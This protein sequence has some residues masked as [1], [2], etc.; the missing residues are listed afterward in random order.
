[1]SSLQEISREC[2]IYSTLMR[3]DVP[4]EAPDFVSARRKLMSHI[5]RPADCHKV[6][7]KAREL[8]NSGTLLMKGKTL[9]LNEERV[10]ERIGALLRCADSSHPGSHHWDDALKQ[11]LREL[12]QQLWV[13]G[14]VRHLTLA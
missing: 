2:A 5:I 12:S 4:I 10:A 8:Y 14:T 6:E 9:C 11:Q 13:G 3:D 1:M 7:E